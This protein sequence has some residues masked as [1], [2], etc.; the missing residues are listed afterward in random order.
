LGFRVG[1]S[2]NNKSQ[3]KEINVIKLPSVDTLR[4]L[5]LKRRAEIQER[6]VCEL[7]DISK[8]KSRKIEVSPP[9]KSFFCVGKCS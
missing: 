9:N 7:Q 8:G 5:S 6:K 3:E 1:A 2:R 4:L